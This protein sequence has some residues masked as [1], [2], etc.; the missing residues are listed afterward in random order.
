MF[1]TSNFQ[2]DSN[3]FIICQ[4]ALA[5]APRSLDAG[6]APASNSI[7]KFINIQINN[8]NHKCDHTKED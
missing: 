7:L 6:D 2:N 8:N 5:P 3:N 4:N 1:G